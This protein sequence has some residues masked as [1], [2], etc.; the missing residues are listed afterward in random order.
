MEQL[1]K[2]LLLEH[3]EYDDDDEE[4]GII[5]GDVFGKLRTIISNYE[6]PKNDIV[7]RFPDIR[8]SMTNF[9]THRFNRV[10]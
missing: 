4:F 6:E 9:V 7:I 2:V 1:V 8:T 3:E 5:E 10:L